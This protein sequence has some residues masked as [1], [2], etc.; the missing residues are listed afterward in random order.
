M[1]CNFGFFIFQNR[2]CGRINLERM[3]IEEIILLKRV[4]AIHFLYFQRH[5]I[6][7][8]VWRQKRQY[9]GIQKNGYQSQVRL[10]CEHELI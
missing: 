9:L 8:N 10:I 4:S 6:T 5:K 7:V 3:A 1:I 2:R